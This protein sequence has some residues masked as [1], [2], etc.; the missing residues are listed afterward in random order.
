ML[1]WLPEH[2]PNTIVFNDQVA[3]RYAARVMDINSGMSRVL[4]L[5][6]SP[7]S[8]TISAAPSA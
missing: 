4:G 2:G 1:H 5:G 3:G 6:R 8:A 7:R